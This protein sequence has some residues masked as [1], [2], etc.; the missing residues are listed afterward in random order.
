MNSPLGLVL[1]VVGA[2]GMEG[3]AS[4]SCRAMLLGVTGGGI[5]SVPCQKAARL[6]FFPL[7]ITEEPT[8][9]C[10]IGAIGNFAQASK[11]FD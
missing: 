6:I 2:D 3:N 8:A 11:A 7:V 9:A 1:V 4:A 10:T 5:L